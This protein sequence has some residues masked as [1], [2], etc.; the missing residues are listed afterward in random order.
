M[1]P[2]R[3]SVLSSINTY[4]ACLVI[5]IVAMLA[6]LAATIRLLPPIPGIGL[7]FF[8]FAVTYGIYVVPF[9]TNLLFCFITKPLR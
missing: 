7:M 6:L 4:T 2:S 9:T 5:S 3:E 1:R 8:V